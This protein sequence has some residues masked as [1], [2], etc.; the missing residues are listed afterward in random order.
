MPTAKTRLLVLRRRPRDL[1][2]RGHRPEPGGSCRSRNAPAPRH[3]SGS[4]PGGVSCGDR[5][6]ESQPEL[7]CYRGASR[8]GI[9]VEGVRDAPH[10]QEAAAEPGPAL[11]V[12]RENVVEPLDP[13]SAIGGDHPHLWCGELAGNELDA[14]GTRIEDDVAR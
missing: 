2:A 6:V 11:V 8:S 13:R 5:R 14:S 4:L 7:R 9:D 12:T 1:R 10:R 3:P